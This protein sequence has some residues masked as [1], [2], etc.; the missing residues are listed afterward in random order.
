VNIRISKAAALVALAALLPAAVRAAGNVRDFVSCASHPCERPAPPSVTPLPAG[1]AMVA[2][3]I[4]IAP[5]HP[6][7]RDLAQ[8]GF[9]LSHQTPAYYSRDVPRSVTLF[10]NSSQA[11]PRGFVQV[12]ATDNSPTAPEKM[13]IQVMDWNGQWVTPE[14]FYV[15]GS[16]ASRLAA[17]WDARG[18]VTGA[19]IYTVV[20]RS[21][22][23][24]AAPQVASMAVRVLIV[25][26]RT[27]PFG[28]GWVLGGY[29]RLH[30]GGNAGGV[31]VTQ[32]DGSALFFAGPAV[33][34]TFT[35]PDGDFTKL[36][37]VSSAA[38]GGGA[39][40]YRRESATGPPSFTPR[41]GTPGP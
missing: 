35:S 40:Y 32:G 39:P 11:N 23:T 22:W 8:S 25:N 2:P 3:T 34:G 29:E 17:Q 1:A 21:H 14:I 16:G 27:S 7:M 30:F 33:D 13:S 10:Y 37:Y 31:T 4:S 5:H 20:V 38:N 41:T 12:D 9:S 24:G 26:E 6:G 36:R 15:S 19:Y 28:A 18:L